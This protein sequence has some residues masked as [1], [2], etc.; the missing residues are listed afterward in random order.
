MVEQIVRAETQILWD[1]DA[2]ARWNI[3]TNIGQTKPVPPSQGGATS[4]SEDATEQDVQDAVQP[5]T[6]PLF[7]NPLWWILE[8]VPTGYKY[9][10]PQ[11]KWI[12]SWW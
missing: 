9:Q 1:Y 8:I 2:F 7:K 10:N 11:G 6:D 4:A 5:I 3:P 12:T